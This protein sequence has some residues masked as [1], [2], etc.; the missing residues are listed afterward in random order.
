MG[1]ADIVIIHDM[2]WNPHNDIQAFSRA[3]RIGQK[4]KVMIYRF[5][6]RNTVEERMTQVCKQKMMLTEL[7]IH[8]GLSNADKDESG[9]ADTL[10]K[11]EVNDILKF[12]VEKLFK[13]DEEGKV[14]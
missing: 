10:S 14:V 6:C 7:V 2:D 4:N 11:K 13:D 8:K 9:K 3:H 1:T 5:V 12:G